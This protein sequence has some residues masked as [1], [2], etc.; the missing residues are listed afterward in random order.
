M[1]RVGTAYLVFC[2]WLFLSGWSQAQGVNNVITYQSSDQAGNTGQIA[3]P[4]EL[5]T[6]DAYSTPRTP[7]AL[8]L[9]GAS[10]F[11]DGNLRSALA[12]FQQSLDLYRQARNAKGEGRALIY[13]GMCHEAV[14]RYQVALDTFY[15]ALNV[16]RRVGDKQGEARSLSEI[17]NTYRVWGYPKEGLHRLK[18]ALALCQS[19][20]QCPAQPTILNHIG[21]TY[22]DLPNYPQ[23]L[24]YFRKALALYHQ[25]EDER[26]IALVFNNIGAVYNATGRFS[27]ALPLLLEAN[28]LARRKGESDLIPMTLCNIGFSHAGLHQP[29]EAEKDYREALALYTQLGR[30]EGENEMRK[31]LDQLLTSVSR[32]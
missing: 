24:R 12:A 4:S 29:A 23:A 31:R 6:V 25:S 2:I 10:Y 21:M 22:F 28:S 18:A 5:K 14:R 8:L 15:L 9:E 20:E 30:Q 32:R 13:I 7:E 11:Q 3:L 16:Q 27:D 1:E 26:Q 17:G 19:L